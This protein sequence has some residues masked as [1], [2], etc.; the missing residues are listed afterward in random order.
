MNHIETEKEQKWEGMKLEFES[1]SYNEGFARVVVA[2][3]M[4]RMDPTVEEVDDVKTAISEAVTNAIIHGYQNGEGIVVIQAKRRERTIQVSI[5]DDGVGIKNITQAMEPLYSGLKGGERSGMGVS[6]MEAFMDE[7][8]VESE[9]GKGTTV[10]MTKHLGHTI[11][12]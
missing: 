8:N 5:H 7:V 1:H 6:F 3:F 10:T 11:Y 9:L 12:K 2:A 4:A